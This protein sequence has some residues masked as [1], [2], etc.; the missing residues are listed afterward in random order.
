MKEKIQQ[1][2][3]EQTRLDEA[4]EKSIAEVKADAEARIRAVEEK[5]L[6]AGAAANEVMA[7]NNVIATLREDAAKRTA[8]VDQ[9]DT[10]NRFAGVHRRDS[11]NSEKERLFE[12]ERNKWTEERQRLE[13]KLDAAVALEATLRKNIGVANEKRD[14]ALAEVQSK[15]AEIVKLREKVR[16]TTADRNDL[17]RKQ[18]ELPVTIQKLEEARKQLADYKTKKD[19]ANVWKKRVAESTKLQE[20]K[21]TADTAK[22]EL[23]EVREEMKE[24]KAKQQ[25][26][27]D[28]AVAQERSKYKD[29]TLIDELTGSNNS[30]STQNDEL[31]QEIAGV[32][33]EL[34]GRDATIAQLKSENNKLAGRIKQYEATKARVQEAKNKHRN[35]IARQNA[36]IPRTPKE[37]LFALLDGP[38]ENIN[39]LDTSTSSGA[40]RLQCDDE[41]EVKTHEVSDEE[42]SSIQPTTQP[43]SEPSRRSWDPEPQHN[44]SDPSLLSERRVAGGVHER[45]LLDTTHEDALETK[46]TPKAVHVA[47]SQ[48]K[49]REASSRNVRGP[50]PDPVEKESESQ[51]KTTDATYIEPGEPYICIRE[52]W[53]RENNKFDSNSKKVKLEPGKEI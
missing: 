50:K 23:S 47:A 19:V 13:S 39:S 10:G 49:I 6:E 43:E 9:K 21:A 14:T 16:E 7:L 28:D 48:P 8:A 45:D 31:T 33:V 26:E 22:S 20:Y 4:R 36:T 32:R 38:I 25:Q 5:L 46:L 34:S 44:N 52:L 11:D 53:V 29:A 2:Q 12:E 30:L 37:E 42:A 41:K 51:H 35:Q 15:D 27:I 3:S 18:K 40:V 1:F 24:L 17:K